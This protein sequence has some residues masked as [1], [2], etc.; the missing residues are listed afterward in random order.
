V[1]NWQLSTRHGL[2][3]RPL[4]VARAD[5]RAGPQPWDR[6]LTSVSPFAYLERGR[7]AEQIGPW[8]AA[9]GD[10]LRVQLLEDLLD[11]PAQLRET[12][13]WLGVHREFVPSS[14]GETVNESTVDA[15]LLGSE[16]TA[17]LRGYF[18]QSD[19]ELEALLGRPLPWSTGAAHAGPAE[20]AE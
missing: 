18:T 14:L 3:T 5:N 1:S 20:G 8:L 10:R 12:F 2:E 17:R 4:A 9:F 6:S 13:A 16:M 11:D 19:S 15:P 7:Y